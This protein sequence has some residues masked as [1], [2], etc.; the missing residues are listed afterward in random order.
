MYLWC[1][2]SSV[3]ST[4]Q[5][6]NCSTPLSINTNLQFSRFHCTIN[7][8]ILRKQIKRRYK[9]FRKIFVFSVYILRFIL[10]LCVNN[11]NFIISYS[12]RSTRKTTSV[13]TR[14]KKEGYAWR[15][16][17]PVEEGNKREE[18]P[19]FQLV[20]VLHFTISSVSPKNCRWKTLAA[21]NVALRKHF[22][23]R[24]KGEE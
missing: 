18:P 22:F 23:P 4:F 8:R 19:L 24:R 5:K 13:E 11:S 12:S 20:L 21:G 3:I 2:I 14:T 10:V 15:A 17:T 16:S 1:V 9:T 6:A 7:V